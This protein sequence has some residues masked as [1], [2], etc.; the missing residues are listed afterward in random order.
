MRAMKIAD[1]RRHTGRKLSY[2]E[3]CTL[4]N[5][6]DP[7]LRNMSVALSL[8]AWNNTAAD[9]LRLEASLVILAQRRRGAA[10]E[11]RRRD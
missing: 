1:V 4:A 6:A 8:H 7:F 3:A 5:P 9:W 2:A 10:G 11:P